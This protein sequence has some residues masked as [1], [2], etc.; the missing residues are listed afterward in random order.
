MEPTAPI[1]LREELTALGMRL[2]WDANRADFGGIAAPSEVQDRIHLSEAFHR[3]QMTVDE[4]GTV[5]A[6][7]SASMGI[8]AGPSPPR[9]GPRRI[10]FDRPFLFELVDVRTNTILFLGLVEDPREL[11]NGR[12]PHGARARE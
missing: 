8:A 11:T 5:A 4:D 9:P 10:A 1:A 12:G 7:A 3:V 6:S 2:A